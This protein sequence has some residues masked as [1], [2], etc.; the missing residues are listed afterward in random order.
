MLGSTDLDERARN[1]DE[2]AKVMEA[3]LVRSL[4]QCCGV[5]RSA[6]GCT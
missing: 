5:P 1:I 2:A 4:R 6:R 3:A